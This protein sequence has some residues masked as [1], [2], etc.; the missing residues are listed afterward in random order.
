MI[1]KLSEFND[2]LVEKN[3]FF[4]FYGKNEYEKKRLIERIFF[5]KKKHALHNYFEEEI[6]RNH[7]FFF[8][9]FMS[10]S[11]FDEKKILKVNQSTDKIFNFISELI[12]KKIEDVMVILNAGA[13]EKTSKLRKLFEKNKDLIVVPTYSDNQ[14]TLTLYANNFFKENNILISQNNINLILNKCN[15]DKEVL[16]NE[17]NKIKL[18][19]HKNKINTEV[20][21]KL[22]NLIENYNIS[23]LV[24]NY[25]AKYYKKTQYILN[26]N[27]FTDED[28][29]LI[30]RI[31]LNKLKK[32]LKLS[33][34]FQQNKDLDKTILSAKP[35][36]FWKDREI[37]KQ[38]I[39]KWSPKEIKKTIFNLNKIE[40]YVKKGLGSPIS[41]VSSFIL[42]H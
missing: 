8:E 11:L 31:L 35:P 18:Y 37:T 29:I 32:N 25:L 17:L 41:L 1:I 40:L 14:K 10:K 15:G 13:L 3:F 36:I 5:L 2:A 38:Q 26:E 19:G 30:I 22:T 9:S 39:L 16:K 7:E 24:D 33:E 27:I 6:L 28:S 21:L 4:L 20:I 42:E 34:S 23:E 12:E